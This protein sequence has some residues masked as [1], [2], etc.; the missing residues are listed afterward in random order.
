MGST[1]SW[2]RDPWTVPALL[3]AGCVTWVMS[4]PVYRNWTLLC[5]LPCSSALWDSKINSQR[6]KKE[7]PLSQACIYLPRGATWF[8]NICAVKSWT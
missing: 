7:K 1:L 5:E 3:L 8:R 4:S 6:A 2:G